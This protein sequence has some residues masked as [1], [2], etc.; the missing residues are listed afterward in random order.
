VSR[1]IIKH[2]LELGDTQASVTEWVPDGTKVEDLK[3][4]HKKGD[5]VVFEVEGAKEVQG[6]SV[7]SGVMHTYEPGA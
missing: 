1:A 7:L 4:V 2:G 3:P 6:F 5:K